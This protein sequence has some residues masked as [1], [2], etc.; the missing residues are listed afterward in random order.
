MEAAGTFFVW[1]AVSAPGLGAPV[2][3]TSS[4]AAVSIY[5]GVLAWHELHMIGAEFEQS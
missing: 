2:G 4:L 1:I 3:V 5:L